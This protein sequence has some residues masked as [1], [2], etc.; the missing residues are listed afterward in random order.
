MENIRHVNFI[1]DRAI[2]YYGYNKIKQLE[3]SHKAGE[4]AV[5]EYA[6]KY[7]IRN[8]NELIN[9]DFISIY[10]LNEKKR[11]VKEIAPDNL[12][13][14]LKLVER[15]QQYKHTSFQKILFTKENGELCVDI[16]Y[17]Y[18]VRVGIELKEKY[19]KERVSLEEGI[20]LLQDYAEANEITDSRKLF[21]R[22]GDVRVVNELIPTY[23]EE[24]LPKIKKAISKNEIDDIK[25][26]VLYPSTDKN[27][28]SVLKAFVFY[29]SGTVENL[30]K[31]MVDSMIDKIALEYDITKE[32]LY[33]KSLNFIDIVSAREVV[34]N[35][36]KY[37]RE[38][39]KS[40]IN[41][42]N[43]LNNMGVSEEKVNVLEKDFEENSSNNKSVGFFTRIKERLQK[44]HLI[45]RGAF[46][47]GALS[48]L[49]T[50]AKLVHD[51]VVGR[52]KQDKVKNTEKQNFDFD[53]KKLEEMVDSMID[54]MGKESSEQTANK[55]YEKFKYNY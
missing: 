45:R 31:E 12:V 24:I 49:G 41:L 2:I 20:D 23:K 55:V 47:L 28:Q 7:D 52:V 4:Y 50:G 44:G 15:M 26:I 33:N 11:T 17:K 18:F 34:A 35:F 51:S 1:N 43:S 13:R 42:A 21:D 53:T 3:V 39:I 19:L 29:N 10:K 9:T 37:R 46:R 48:L 5:R 40:N 27:N 8:Y 22:I 14:K 25:K 30:S 36:K 16:V 38:A 32:E 6:K 54:Y